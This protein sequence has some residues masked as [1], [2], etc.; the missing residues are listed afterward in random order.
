MQTVSKI[1]TAALIA[2]AALV[3]AAQACSRLAKQSDHGVA[4]VRSV[5]WGKQTGMDL[6]TYAAGDDVT[7]Y[8]AEGFAQQAD[9]AAKNFVVTWVENDA[10]HGV[11]AQAHNDKGMV[12]D[13]LYMNP[14][15]DFISD[16][17]DNGA[18]AINT[19]D[20][21]AYIASQYDTAPA[22]AA[23]YEN[24]DFQI[25][26][27]ADTGEAGK[28]GLHFSAVDV[29][30]DVTWFQLNEGGEVRMY[31]GN[32]NDTD[33]G[34]KANAPLLQDHRAAI[35]AFDAT[36]VD[37]G[38]RLPSDISSSS[39]HLRL[40]WLSNN[41]SFEGM[42]E[43][44]TLGAIQNLYDAGASVPQQIIDSSINDTYTT[45]KTTRTILGSD[46]VTARDFATAQ[47]I[48]FSISEA[49]AAHE[50]AGGSVCA[51]ANAQARAGG[52]HD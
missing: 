29:N 52:H 31:T 36:A 30:G 11:Q 39:R 3:P 20:V 49:K 44:E 42:S 28:H 43:M 27:S 22:V 21:P 5:D 12:V 48:S 34:V 9:G 10:F 1:I 40:T 6:V 7:S 2:S 13:T 8:E 18:P 33:L 16:Y 51:D 41:M 38:D 46:I 50:A 15:V 14:S 45:W 35:D 32:I 24:G 19:A 23:G 37:A 47:E 4:Y 25:A 26:W 17:K